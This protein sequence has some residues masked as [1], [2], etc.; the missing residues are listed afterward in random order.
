MVCQRD[1]AI[2]KNGKPS[3][4]IAG[5]VAWCWQPAVKRDDNL[6][7]FA[8]VRDLPLSQKYRGC[9]SST[10]SFDPNNQEDTCLRHA[11]KRSL[12]LPC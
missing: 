9:D 6:N 12:Q 10:S 8:G 2:C 3:R 7:Y 4:R 1:A 11:W 5:C